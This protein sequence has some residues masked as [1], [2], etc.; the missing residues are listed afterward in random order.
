MGRLIVHRERALGAFALKYHCFFGKDREAFLGLLEQTPLEERARIPSDCTLKNGEHVTVELGE[1][2]T[3]FFV[4]VYL[5]SRNIVT[6]LVEVPP[7]DSLYT[8]VTD[9]DRYL[10]LSLRVERG[11]SET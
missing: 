3:C 1:Q 6:P 7:G 9:F 2:G 4:A 5:E 11:Q 8:I 10:G